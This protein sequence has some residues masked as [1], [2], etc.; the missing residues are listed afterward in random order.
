MRRFRTHVRAFLKDE[1]GLILAEALIL[2]PILIWGFIAL[3]VYWDLFR[4][5]NVSQKAAYSISDVL[6]RQELPVSESF[7]EGMPDL[8]EF[9]TPDASASRLRIT[10]LQMVEGADPG[11]NAQNANPVFDGN[12]D[13]CLLF[14]R[15][16][17]PL[18]PELT[19]ADLKDL[20]P[21]IPNMNAL[22]T[23]V[24][25]ETWVDY[26]PAF[27]TGVLNV[28]PGAKGQTFYEFIVTR[29]RNVR[30]VLLDGQAHACA[31]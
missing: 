17:N 18:V 2:L 6:S 20:A 13:F 23:V 16:S 8:L 1:S 19:Q 28:A 3:V 26:A 30:R 10:S 22:E 12:D 31:T 27:D 4:V 25:V 21:Q 5:M 7:I 24:I 15:S 29:P 14:S 11:F 9:L